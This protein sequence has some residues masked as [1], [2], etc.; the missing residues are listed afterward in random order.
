MLPV[1]EY[2]RLFILLLRNLGVH[3]YKLWITKY[4]LWYNNIICVIFFSS[5]Y[6]INDRKINYKTPNRIFFLRSRIQWFIIKFKFKCNMTSI[7]V[8]STVLNYEE[9]S[10]KPSIL[11][12]EQ[13]NQ[14]F[15]ILNIWNTSFRRR[16]QNM[17]SGCR[18]EKGLNPYKIINDLL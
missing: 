4:K 8:T 6:C 1:N 18:R 11:Y 17:C 9:H 5:A 10:K 2:I 3:T 14:C 12:V 13:V 16:V 15:I 7:K